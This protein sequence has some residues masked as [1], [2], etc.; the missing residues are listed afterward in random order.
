MF[1]QGLAGQI[2][3][4]E[5]AQSPPTAIRAAGLLQSFRDCKE[6]GRRCS[7]I[8]DKVY[9]VSGALGHAGLFSRDN[10]PA[11]PIAGH[12]GR[13]RQT[14]G[15]AQPAFARV[16]GWPCLG[17]TARKISKSDRLPC[18]SSMLNT[19]MGMRQKLNCSSLRFKFHSVSWPAHRCA[20]N[21]SWQS[22]AR[23]KKLKSQGGPARM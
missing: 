2:D 20:R 16:R 11:C 4:T 10:R 5:D 6:R 17:S 23:H 9:S 14:A 3:R 8:C 18:H 12:A 22:I 21:L 7:A 15:P 13:N 19:D 1:W